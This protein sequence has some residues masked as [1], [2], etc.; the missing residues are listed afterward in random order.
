M[1]NYTEL[2]VPYTRIIE[3]KHFENIQS[4]YS[5]VSWE[6]PTQYIIGKSEP[7]YPINDINNNL[8]YLRYKEK[9]NK[10]NNVFFGGRLGEY[11]YYNMDD[12]I[13]SALNFIKNI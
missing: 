3:H 4:D 12:V 9:A 13:K 7:Y 2:E 8:I 6:F 5:W 1:M 11:K 10:I